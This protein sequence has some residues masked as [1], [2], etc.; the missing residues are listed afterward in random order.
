MEHIEVEDIEIVS[1]ISEGSSNTDELIKG[2]RNGSLPPFVTKLYDMVSNEAMDSTIS[3]VGDTRFVIWNEQDFI[4]NLL[5]T[6]SKS[7]NFDSFVTQL[8]NYGFKKISWDRREYA[9]ESFQKGKRHLLKNIK[10]RS[11]GNTSMADKMTCEIQKLECESKELDLELSKFKE[12]V[13]NTLSDQKRIVQ[14]MAN[15]IKSTFDQ[16]HHVRGAHMSKET[17]NNNKGKGAQN[18]KTSELGQSS[19]SQSLVIEVEDEDI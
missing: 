6:M 11:K 16:Y 1:D 17:N 4:I 18:L 5:P 15:A 7:N 10:R 9:H 3:W 19:F 8:N 12:Y 2:V 13:D 14:A